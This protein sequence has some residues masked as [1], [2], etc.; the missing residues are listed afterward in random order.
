[1]RRRREPIWAFV[2]GSILALSGFAGITAFAQTGSTVQIVEIQPLTGAS[3][4]YGQQSVDGSQVA[5]DIINA[6]GGVL[7]KKIELVAA[8]DA[9]DK[10]Q[11][12]AL[13]R[14]YGPDQTVPAI[15]GPTF[16]SDFI[17]TTPL[18]AEF[19]VLYISAGSTAPWQGDFNDWTFRSSIPGNAF[20]PTL[21]KEVVARA[22]PRTAAQIWAIDNQALAVQGKLLDTL[23]PQNGI[24]VTVDE[25]SRNNDADFSAQISR[26]MQTPPDLIAIG[27]ITNDAA[28][29]MEQARRA[30]YK[31]LFMANGST[32]LD[33]SLFQLSHGGA[34]GLLV[35]SPFDP[36]EKSAIVQNFDKAFQAKYKRLP[37]AQDAFGYD[38]LALIVDAMQRS[39]SVTDRQKIR[40]ALGATK[41]FR[42]VTGAFTFAGK[43]D[44]TTPTVHVLKL[45]AAGFVAY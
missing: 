12:A 5:A 3:G 19:K 17:A 6:R 2:L 38:A 20:L 23:F 36:N 26:I 25:T 37:T 42:G 43:G 40:D 18:A 34:N 35:G 27:L 32:L 30:G 7:G 9:S 14:K 44:N 22:H 29:F 11:T 21:V 13:M 39:R 24:K 10:T 15:I 28:L 16:S 41:G 4:Q 8:D 33:P 31:G 1:M 45:T